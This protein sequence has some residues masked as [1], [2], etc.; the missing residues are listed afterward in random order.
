MEYQAVIDTLGWA[1]GHDLPVRVALA[2][3]ESVVGVPTS[4]DIHPTALEVYLRP[5]GDQDT[6]IAL[7]LAS[8]QSVELAVSH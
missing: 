7:S 5:I 6:E 8:I 4:L 3:G 1:V 2:G